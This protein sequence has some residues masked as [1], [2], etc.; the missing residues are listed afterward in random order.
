LRTLLM[1]EA[2]LLATIDY[3]QYERQF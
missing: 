2:R 1:A 3:K